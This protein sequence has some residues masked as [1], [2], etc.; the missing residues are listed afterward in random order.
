MHQ[1]KIEVDQMGQ[2]HLD[3]FFVEQKPKYVYLTIQS[4]RLKL[5]QVTRETRF[6]KFL[7]IRYLNSPL[8]PSVPVFFSLALIF[9]HSFIV[10]EDLAITFE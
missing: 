4:L 10:F 2:Q 7:K 8:Y 1:L 3:L 6:C 5:K 9:L